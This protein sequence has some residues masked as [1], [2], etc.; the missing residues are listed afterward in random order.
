MLRMETVG[1]SPD[2]LELRSGPGSC[3]AERD[4]ANARP[5]TLL[6]LENSEPKQL[7]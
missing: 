4:T 3:R 7:F 1:F 6:L 2:L 5:N